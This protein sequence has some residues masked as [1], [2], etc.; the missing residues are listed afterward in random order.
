[1]KIALKNTNSTKKQKIKNGL[2]KNPLK[3]YF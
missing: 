1:M 3:N 2:N